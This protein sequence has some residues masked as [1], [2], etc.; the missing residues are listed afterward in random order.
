M[1]LTVNDLQNEKRWQIVE[2]FEFLYASVDDIDLFIAG[3]SE[4][5]AP[6]AMVGPT[7]QCIIAD[8]FLRLKRGDRFFYDLVGQTGSFTEGSFNYSLTFH[9]HLTPFS[10]YFRSTKWNPQSELLASGVWQQPCQVH[11]ATLLQ[12]RVWSVS[13]SK[14]YIWHIIWLPISG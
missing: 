5:P 6:G 14:W 12:S 10:Y 3:V 13:Y 7:F 2:K 1:F 8:Q 9:Y 4:R 11:S